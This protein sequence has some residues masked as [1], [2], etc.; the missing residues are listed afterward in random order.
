MDRVLRVSA[1]AA[2]TYAAMFSAAFASCGSGSVE[3]DVGAAEACVTQADFDLLSPEV[4]AMAE[5]PEPLE[6]EDQDSDDQSPDDVNHAD[7]DNH[8]DDHGRVASND[9]D[10]HAN[11]GDDR[12][13]DSHGADGG[14]GGES[15]DGGGDHGG[16]AKDD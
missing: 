6:I 4:Q 15:H 7:D 3:I 9:S 11:E 12:G 1:F 5:L 10:D 14:H 16:D 2:V 8:A 13:G